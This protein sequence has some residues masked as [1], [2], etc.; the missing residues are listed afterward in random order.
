MGD[1][2]TRREKWLRLAH[3]RLMSS[4]YCT[5]PSREEYV[6]GSCAPASVPTKVEVCVS[7]LLGTWSVF[8][9]REKAA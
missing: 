4:N 2:E 7:K 1:S 3:R 6:A 5:A 8:M 9:S